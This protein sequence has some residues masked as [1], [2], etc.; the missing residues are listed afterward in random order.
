MSYDYVHENYNV[1]PIVGRRARHTE[2]AKSG[3]IMS[4][5]RS[6]SHYVMVR[7]DGQKFAMPCHPT[8]L[9]YQPKAV[10]NG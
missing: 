7:F 3:T 8:A 6:M 9:D 2:T 1:R 5:N 10:A 4:E